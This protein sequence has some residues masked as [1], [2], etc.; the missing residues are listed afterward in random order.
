MVIEFDQAALI[1]W[2]DHHRRLSFYSIRRFRQGNIDKCRKDPG[3][4]PKVV[5]RK[6]ITWQRRNKFIANLSRHEVGSGDDP[7]D[8]MPMISFIFIEFGLRLLK[9]FRKFIY[10]KRIQ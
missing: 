3:R 8:L 7:P 1:F 5:S 9:N 10:L 4:L 2:M 6:R